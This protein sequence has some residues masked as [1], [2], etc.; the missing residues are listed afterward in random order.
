MVE[1]LTLNQLVR[2]SSPRG[3]TKID[4]NRKDPA[5]AP[6]EGTRIPK[7]FG[8]ARLGRKQAV[9]QVDLKQPPERTELAPLAQNTLGYSSE[10]LS[11]LPLN[12]F[13]LL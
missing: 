6:T 11:S 9:D 4:A 5:I 7:G 1:Q 10:F 8:G 3:G 12:I 2:G 13:P